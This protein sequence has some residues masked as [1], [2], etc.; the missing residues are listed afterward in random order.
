MNKLQNNKDYAFSRKLLLSMFRE[1]K[2]VDI[3]LERFVDNDAEVNLRLQGLLHRCGNINAVKEFLLYL[4]FETYQLQEKDYSYRLS[5]LGDFE[6]LNNSHVFRGLR[7]NEQEK[8][9]KLMHWQ[10]NRV[11]NMCDYLCC[12]INT[13][14][15]KH[16]LDIGC[17]IGQLSY[18]LA[19]KGMKVTGI[20]LSIDQALEIQT[21]FAEKHSYAKNVIFKEGDAL[22]IFDIKSTFDLITLADVVEHITEKEQLFREIDNKLTS[23][24]IIAIHTDNLTKLKF[25]K[26]LKRIIYLLTFRN[27]LN[28]NLAWSGGEGGHVGLQTPESIIGYL[29]KLNFKTMFKYDKDGVL[30]KLIPNLFANGF[31]LI[32]KK[33]D[34][35]NYV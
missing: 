13:S 30:S 8:L 25:L 19:E 29:E 22:N 23:N 34:G 15:N 24:G 7:K 4:V 9:L 3:T 33:N 1:S 10:F 2:P 27:P 26:F 6:S 5:L 21:V 32:A 12:N 31:V 20:D 17:G 18:L 16:V 14:S 35:Y 11:K 28:Y